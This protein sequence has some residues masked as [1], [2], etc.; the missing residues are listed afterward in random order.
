VNL[1]VG[2]SVTVT[3]VYT[4][5]SYQLSAGERTQSVTMG[6]EESPRVSFTNRWNGEEVGGTSVNNHFVYSA[7]EGRWDWTPL[8][9]S[10]AE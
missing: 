6:G 5:S 2:A 9:D 8:A 7:A 3:E 1:P 10:T 4:G